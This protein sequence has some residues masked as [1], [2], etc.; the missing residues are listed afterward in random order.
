M[1][2]TLISHCLDA[3]HN[4]DYNLHRI[5]FIDKYILICLG[6]STCRY[7]SDSAEHWFGL[8]G[9]RLKNMI[10]TLITTNTFYNNLYLVYDTGT[11]YI[12]ICYRG[13]TCRYRSDSAEHWF[14]LPGI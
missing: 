10:V 5:H 14:G 3:C 6:G 2:C 1:N 12:L 8:T 4:M 9:I 7:R 13:S 11:K